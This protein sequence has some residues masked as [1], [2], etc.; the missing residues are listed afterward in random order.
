MSANQVGAA[1]GHSGSADTSSPS[2]ARRTAEAIGLQ[3]LS[4][5]VALVL[6][7]ATFGALNPA[8]LSPA[9]LAVIGMT[10][11]VAGLLAVVQTVVIICGA[12]DISVGSQAGLA[13]VASAMAFTASGGNPA[14]GM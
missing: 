13:S 10:A 4:L 6:V 14:V 3:N 8:Y 9:N 2:L 1:M 11:T 12:L 7:L 5:A